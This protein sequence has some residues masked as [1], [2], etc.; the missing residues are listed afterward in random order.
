MSS[1]LSTETG[2]LLIVSGVNLICCAA[3][4]AA[5]HAGRS[6]SL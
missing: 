5:F 2:T 3:F 1:S 6:G 4:T